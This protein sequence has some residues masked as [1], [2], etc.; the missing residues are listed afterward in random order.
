MT[1]EETLQKLNLLGIYDPHQLDE[2]DLYMWWQKK[3]KE[4][5]D[6]QLK[7]ETIRE[8]LMEINE[9]YEDLSKVDEKVLFEIINKMSDEEN[10][11]YSDIDLYNQGLDYYNQNEYQKS[12]KKF[13][14]AIDL[15]S[16]DPDYFKLRGWANYFLDKYEQAIEDLSKAIN[17]NSDDPDAFKFRGWALYE[18]KEYEEAILNFNIAIQIDKT[19]SQYFYG[20]FLAKLNSREIYKFRD[21]FNELNNALNLTDNNL[22]KHE[23]LYHRGK[24]YLQTDQYE[25]ALAD[26]NESIEL[27]EE[28]YCIEERLYTLIQLQEFSKAASD[29]LRCCDLDPDNINYYKRKIIVHTYLDESLLE[30]RDEILKRIQKA[31]LHPSWVDY[32]ENKNEKL[33]NDEELTFSHLDEYNKALKMVFISNQEFFKIFEKT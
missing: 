22:S 17:L 28:I 30:T 29:I 27:K 32:I 1:E 33:I 2:E 26:F 3:Y 25:N 23:I 21:L 14:K 4:I 31:G 18:I 20:R 16:D 7:K 12:I 6:S 9:I 19:E 10:I 11:V 5:K 8:K 13:S 24:L 15:N